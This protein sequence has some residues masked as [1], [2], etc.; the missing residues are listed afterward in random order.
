MRDRILK[1]W[2]LFLH[3]C[4]FNT[5]SI[6]AGSMLTFAWIT[7]LSLYFP[8]I[9]TLIVCPLLTF[10]M[11]FSIVLLSHKMTDITDRYEF[12][13]N[14]FGILLGCLWVIFLAFI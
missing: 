12:Q 8:L 4:M 3:T 14:T 5:F 13:S 11:Y 6:V 7:G 9:T 2:L 1:L 10:A